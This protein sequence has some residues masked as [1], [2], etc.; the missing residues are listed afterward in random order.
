MHERGKSKID[1]IGRK[2]IV[3]AECVEVVCWFVES[4]KLGYLEGAWGVC[5]GR[6]GFNEWIG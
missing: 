6:R 1:A 2:L 3:G 5:K 4:V